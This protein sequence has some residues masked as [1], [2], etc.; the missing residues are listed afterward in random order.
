LSEL[1]KEFWVALMTGGASQRDGEITCPV[2][3]ALTWWLVEEVKRLVS[4]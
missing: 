3:K 4:L 1:V 2:M